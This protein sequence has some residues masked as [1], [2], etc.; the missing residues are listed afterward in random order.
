MYSF[1]VCFINILRY[2]NVRKLFEFYDVYYM[3]SEIK[4]MS[5]DNVLLSFNLF[6]GHGGKP[7]SLGAGQLPTTWEKRSLINGRQKK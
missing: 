1:V 4:L 2:L 3:L 7:R 6:R 5:N